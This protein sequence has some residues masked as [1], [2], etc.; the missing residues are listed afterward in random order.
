MGAINLFKAP[1]GSY[2]GRALFFAGQGKLRNFVQAINE[3]IAAA[4]EVDKARDGHWTQHMWYG[5][6][7][8]AFL[9]PL[10]RWW[11]RQ[12]DQLRYGTF[13]STWSGPRLLWSGHAKPQRAGTEEHWRRMHLRF[14]HAT[15]IKGV[16]VECWF[17]RVPINLTASKCT[18]WMNWTDH[19][20]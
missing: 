7:T 13:W 18:H 6:G 11:R 20:R 9:D 2:L 5:M 4:V 17:K 14:G 15:G 16:G 10:S 8:T 1:C 3:A 19:H 12:T